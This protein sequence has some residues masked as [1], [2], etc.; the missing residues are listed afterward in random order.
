[1]SQA[2]TMMKGNLSS[3]DPDG[4]QEI[5]RHDGQTPRAVI[6]NLQPS[7]DQRRQEEFIRSLMV[8]AGV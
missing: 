1:M 2:N 6:Q 7:S 4:I 8:S 3:T 5:I